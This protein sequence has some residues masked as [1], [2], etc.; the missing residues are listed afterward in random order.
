M[1]WS[2]SGQPSE[3]ECHTLRAPLASPALREARTH[4]GPRETG[5]ARSG[6][7]SDTT[8][9]VAAHNTA[10]R[11]G[12]THPGILNLKTKLFVLPT[13][14]LL[15]ILPPG[16]V[17]QI[18]IFR[19]SKPSFLCYPLRRCSKCATHCVAAH[20]AIPK[21]GN[22]NPGILNL[23]TKLFVLPTTSLL[24][25]PPRIWMHKSLDFESSKPD[26]LCYPL[27]RCLRCCPQTR[28]E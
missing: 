26:F 28:Y 8:H 11:L 6:K 5:G 18:L 24:T 3:L 10:P 2:V 4:A 13:A 25:I 16:L 21:P 15:T 23:K 9:C 17:A 7:R 12:S 1:Y 20:N 22:T 19:I 14:S 27:R